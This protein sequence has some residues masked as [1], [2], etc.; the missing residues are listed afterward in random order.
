[1]I[2]TKGIVLKALKYKESSLI[3]DI[4]TEDQGLH[5]FL[6]NSVYKKEIKG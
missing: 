6:I 2:R 1:M 3:L 5:S 4:F